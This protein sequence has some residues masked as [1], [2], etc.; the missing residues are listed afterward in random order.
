MGNFHGASAWQ[1]LPPRDPRTRETAARPG[2]RSADHPGG[3]GDQSVGPA[4]AADHRLA[5]RDQRPDVRRDRHGEDQDLRVGSG[6]HARY[7]AAGRRAGR[8]RGDGDDCGW[9]AALARGRPLL[10]QQHA[11]LRL[12]LPDCRP[13]LPTRRHRGARRGPDRDLL[14]AGVRGLH[15]VASPQ[16]RRDRRL[17]VLPRRLLAGT[18]G[19]RGSLRRCSP[20]ICS[21]PS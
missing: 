10:P 16:L 4:A 20:P 15:A 17:P 12:G 8:G 3:D 14:P 2:W 7:G 11:H 1:R 21:R 6:D 9:V 5:R 18:E 19:S 13:A